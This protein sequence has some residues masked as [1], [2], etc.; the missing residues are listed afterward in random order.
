MKNGKLNQVSCH[1]FKNQYQEQYSTLG[2][3][4]REGKFSYYVLGSLIINIVRYVNYIIQLT[5]VY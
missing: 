3:N 2:N 4:K 5:R 1:F